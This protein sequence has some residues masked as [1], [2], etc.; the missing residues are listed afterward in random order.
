MHP[1]LEMKFDLAAWGAELTPDR[2][3]IWFSGRWYNYRDLNERATRLAN[4]LAT[5]GVGFGARVGILAQNHLAHFDLLF[6]APKLGFVLVPYNVR[7]STAELREQAAVTR[8]ELVFCD[9]RGLPA[10]NEVFGCPRVTLEEYRKWLG[11]SSRRQ[12]LAPPL[13]PESLQMILFTGGSTGQSKAVMIP[14]R[15]TLANAQGTAMGWDLGPEDCAI[16]A[17]P[18]YHAAL[19]VLSTPLLTIGGRVVLMTQFDAG[20]YLK[21]AERFEATVMFMVP[22]MF[23]MLA[24][25]PDFATADL[26][27]MRWAIAGGAPSPPALARRFIDRGVPFKQGYGMTEVGVN[28]FGI[29]VEEAVRHPDSVGRPLPHVQAVIRRTDGSPCQVGEVGELTFSG[30]ALCAGY[31]HRNEDWLDVF[32]G[33]SFWTGDLAS[34]DA[35]GR[36]FIRGRSKDMYISGGENVYPAEVEAALAQCAGVAECAV[37]GIADAKWGETGLAA[38]VARGG[39]PRNPERLRTD[40]RSHL[41]AY[42]VPSVVMFLNQLPRTTVGKVDRAALRQMIEADRE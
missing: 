14:Y 7:L 33:E 35:D 17:T 42:K 28:C 36:F 32:R 37:I 13:S 38:V 3:A 11:H 30:E 34:R 8:P 23:Q 12:V 5:M 29:E 4:Q 31:F 26:S 20:E 27:R 6:A 9:A 22:S 1:K 40:L 10:A 16:Q 41:A 25:H 19:N 18:C 21:L 24:E 15:Q 2:P 39:A